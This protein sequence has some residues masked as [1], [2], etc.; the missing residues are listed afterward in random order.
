[1]IDLSLVHRALAP[2]GP[3]IGLGESHAREL[4]PVVKHN[5]D[6]A[7]REFVASLRDATADGQKITA[8]VIL[9]RRETAGLGVPP[10]G[11]SPIGD[12]RLAFLASIWRPT[13]LM[14]SASLWMALIAD[15]GS[16]AEISLPASSQESSD[17]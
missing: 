13:A 1:M 14:A 11:L 9:V 17:E 3:V 10:S 7:A 5:G 4:A 8:T 12:G 6:E 2:L 16:E 15:P